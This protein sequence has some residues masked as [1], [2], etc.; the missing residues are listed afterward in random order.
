VLQLSGK[1]H[2]LVALTPAKRRRRLLVTRL[3]QSRSGHSAAEEK[4]LPVLGLEPRLLR[5]GQS[6]YWMS[7]PD[8]SDTSELERSYE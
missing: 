4:I 5:D 6:F 7:D 1:F 3:S 8:T 2:A